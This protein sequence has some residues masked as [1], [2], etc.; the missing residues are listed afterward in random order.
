MGR[1]LQGYTGSGDS[2]FGKEILVTEPNLGAR[3][4]RFGFA[5]VDMDDVGY[6]DGVKAKARLNED[7][8][9]RSRDWCVY[10]R[11]IGLIGQG[12]F[13]PPNQTAVINYGTGGANQE[14]RY[15]V[16]PYGLA[17]HFTAQ[18]L[19]L[20]LEVVNTLQPDPRTWTVAGSVQP[21]RPSRTISRDFIFPEAP[22]PT[23]VDVP[24]PPFA[25]DLSAVGSAGGAVTEECD[26]TWRY[27]TLP[28]GTVE[29]GPAGGRGCIPGGYV[30][31]PANANIARIG[32]ASASP[33][34]QLRLSWGLQA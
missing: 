28:I 2:V 19:T 9:P 25:V 7:A 24:I 17:M 10:V 22:A 4:K 6:L 21:G 3:A 14:L 8:F 26:V 16:P 13:T 15:R 5:D 20:A 32:L 12:G 31:T 33:I 34:T 23:F 11:P 30:V 27:D 18:Y 1:P 29:A